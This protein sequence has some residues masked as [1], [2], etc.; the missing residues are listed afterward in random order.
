MTPVSAGSNP[1]TFAIDRFMGVRALTQ[2]Q[3]TFAD[4][5][6]KRRCKHGSAKEAAIEAGYSEKTAASIAY[7][8]LQ[9]E[10]VRNYIQERKNKLA[11]ELREEFL[12]DAIEARQVM[13][14]ILKSENAR[15]RDR[16]AAAIDFLDRAGFKSTEKL[17][18]SGEDDALDKLAGILEQLKQ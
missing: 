1:A 10:D 18:V 17:E 8:L 11:D 15:N 16:I 2:Q 4:E 7:N 9:R 14:K 5:F 13:N 3:K 12:F 6:I